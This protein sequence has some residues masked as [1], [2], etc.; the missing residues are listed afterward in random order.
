M[1]RVSGQSSGGSPCVPGDHH[2]RRARAAVAPLR[3]WNRSDELA[4][5][6]PASQP[7]AATKPAMQRRIRDDPF[8]S[9]APDLLD[10]RLCFVGSEYAG[11]ACTSWT[12]TADPRTSLL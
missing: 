3:G 1:C 12:L 6:G 7:V 2:H 9:L 11:R 8:G 5:V 4:A 10:G